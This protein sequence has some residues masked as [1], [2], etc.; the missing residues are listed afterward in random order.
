MSRG[1]EGELSGA[2]DGAEWSIPSQ[3]S[4][5]RGQGRGQERWQWHTDLLNGS[6]K[7]GCSTVPRADGLR[8]ALR[9]TYRNYPHVK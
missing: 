1:L 8:A 2:P 5:K 6:L 7:Q 4:A 3:P 9:R